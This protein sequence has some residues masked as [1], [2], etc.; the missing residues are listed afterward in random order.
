M[1]INGKILIVDDEETIRVV[2]ADALESHQY[3]VAQAANADMAALLCESQPFDVA[4]VDLR[5]P[6][7][8]DGMTLMHLL[9][10]RTPPVDVI[11]LTAYATLD[12]SLQALRQGASD[13]LLKP[14]STLQVLEVVRR[15]MEKRQSEQQRERMIVEIEQLLGRLKGESLE[16]TPDGGQI[17]Q[18]PTLMIDFQKRLVVRQGKPLTLTPTE[19]DMLSY[20]AMN[21]DRVVS[22]RELI[23]AAQGYQSSED[24]ARPIV[25]VNI[26]RLRQKIEPDPK[27]PT[28]IQTHR[29]RGYRFVPG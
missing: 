23:Q 24:E 10:Q 4:L 18:T 13:Y 6:G 22:C 20:L 25:R 26:R 17:V 5:M 15:C 1:T 3:Y 11:I 9:R 27:H 14:V 29:D 7:Q 28:Y 8:M 16:K 21:S 19:F 12:T 2:L